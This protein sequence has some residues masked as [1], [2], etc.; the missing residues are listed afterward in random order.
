MLG[1]ARAYIPTCFRVRADDDARPCILPVLLSSRPSARDSERSAIGGRGEKRG[2]RT[3]EARWKKAKASDGEELRRRRRRF[4]LR[5]FPGEFLPPLRGGR[6]FGFFAAVGAPTT[7]GDGGN[8]FLSDVV[9]LSSGPAVHGDLHE[10]ETRGV[11]VPPPGRCPSKESI[12][13]DRSLPPGDA[14]LIVPDKECS[15]FR[16]SYENRWDSRIPLVA[17]V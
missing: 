9:S 2:G 3:G 15:L 6:S 14:R 13:R 12:S 10:S 17:Q 16:Y 4:P 8:F 5:S 7:C 11:T 1:C